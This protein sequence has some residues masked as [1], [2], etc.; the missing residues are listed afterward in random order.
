MRE[1][2]YQWHLRLARASLVLTPEESSL[3]DRWQGRFPQAGADEWPGWT[4][5]IGERPTPKPTL[6]FR[7]ER[8]A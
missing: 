8:S 3:L 4:A 6:A 1:R 5:I 7:R 2:L